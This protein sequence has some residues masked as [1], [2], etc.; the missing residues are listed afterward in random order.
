[1]TTALLV[2]DHLAGVGVGALFTLIWLARR[3]ARIRAWQVENLL[4]HMAR[5][6]AGRNVEPFK[7][8]TVCGHLI[9]G[10]SLGDLLV[11]EVYH[12]RT[13]EQTNRRAS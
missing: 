13:C 7:V 9:F 5:H 1:M 10:D 11:N 2:V 8:R 6:P 3:H 4:Q 12:A